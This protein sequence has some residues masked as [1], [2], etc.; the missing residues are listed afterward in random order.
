MNEELQTENKERIDYIW[1]VS[2]VLVTAIASFLRFFW[3]EL[4]PLHH[5]EG[6]NGYFLTTLFRSGEYKYDPANYH[7]PDLYYIALAFTKTFGLNTLSIRGSVAVFGVLTVVPAFFLKKYIGKTGSL[8]AALFLALSP[9]MVYISRYFIHEILFVF[10]SFGIVVAI[11]FFIE[12]RKAGIGATVWISLLLLICFLPSALNLANVL[13]AQN[14]MLLWVLR[15]V[16]FLVEVSLVFF[17]VKMLLSWNE[18][19][20]IYLSLGFGFGGAAVCDEGNGFYHYRDNGDCRRLRL[21]VAQ[22]QFARRFC[23]KQI[24]DFHDV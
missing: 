20:P 19:Q 22:N 18:G 6:V 3:L 24:L 12:K 17:V 9:G 1:L 4:K 16:F 15:V 2:C 5:D 23:A 14:E 13:G 7:G 21:A 11:L 10:F 8:F